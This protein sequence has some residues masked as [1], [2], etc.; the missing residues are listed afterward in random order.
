MTGK[1]L[2][3]SLYSQAMGRYVLY[4]A[5]V[6]SGRRQIKF[7]LWLVQSGNEQVSALL[8]PRP[9]RQEAG[10]GQLCPRPVRPGWRKNAV[11]VVRERSCALADSNYL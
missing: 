6:R 8:C 2:I 5:L 7:H 10:G 11:L 3:V 4:Y 9:V 1:E